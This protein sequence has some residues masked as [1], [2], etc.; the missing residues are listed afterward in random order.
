MNTTRGFRQRDRACVIAWLRALAE[1]IG[2]PAVQ[3]DREVAQV[4]DEEVHRIR[5]ATWKRD[6]VYRQR[7]DEEAQS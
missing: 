6:G 1:I 3:R 7:M 4:Y 5:T 2:P